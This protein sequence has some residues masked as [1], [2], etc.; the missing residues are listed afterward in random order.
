MP[1]PCPPS[2]SLRRASSL[3]IILGLA[4]FTVS[5]KPVPKS[6]LLVYPSWSVQYADSAALFI[7]MSVVDTSTVWAAGTGGR[8]ARTTDGGRTWS[9]AVVPGADSLQFRDVAAFSDREA[10]VLSIGNGPMSR[11]YHTTDGGSSWRLSFENQDPKAFFDCFSFWDRK[12]GVAFS[13]SHDGQFTLIRTMDGGATWERVD[14]SKVPEA[15][16]GEGGFAA[17]GTCITTRPGGLA[18]FGTGASAVDTRVFRT[19]DY[20]ATWQAAP[21]PIASPSTTAGI[22]SIAFR[23]DEHGVIVGG[24][25]GHRDSLY[26]NVAVTSDGGVTWTMAGRTGLPGAMFAVAYVPGAAEP[27]L[28]AVC[29]QGSAY[30]SDEGRTWTRIDAKNYWTAAFASTDAG[31][32]AGQGQ[33]SRIRNGVR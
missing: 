24:D 30:S 4:A 6:S 14:T 15:R 3:A 32:A 26:D 19:S 1:V 17:S 11:I 27:T 16:P 18:W 20:G 21:T 13:D 10:F 23:D 31:W 8:V 7:G 33:I 2:V 5:C 12:R 28:V 29:P 9:V 22:F 25:D